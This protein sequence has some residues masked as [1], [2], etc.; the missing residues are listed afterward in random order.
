MLGHVLLRELVK[1][2]TY[3]IHSTVRGKN[4]FVSDKVS[5]YQNIDVANFDLVKSVLDKV[6]PDVVINCVGVIKQVNNSKNPRISYS[7]NSIFPQKLSVLCDCAKVK[8]VHISTDCVYTGGKGNYS[9]IDEPNAD[10]TYGTS[11]LLGEVISGQDITLRSSLIGPE[12]I[13]SYGLLEWF[14]QSGR[15]CEGYANAFFSGF[16]TL[17]FSRILRDVVLPNSNLKGLYH[18]ASWK[19]SKGD[20]IQKINEKFNLDRYINMVPEPK[21]DRTLNGSKFF[22]ETGYKAPNWDVMIDSMYKDYCH[23]SHLYKSLRIR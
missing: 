19:I 11:K 16:T 21:I 8:L 5:Y 2:D 9:E 7:I 18:I 1:N 10:D 20:L 12:L 22:S 15:E 4:V 13:E 23:N 14:L 3:S 17:E 6:S